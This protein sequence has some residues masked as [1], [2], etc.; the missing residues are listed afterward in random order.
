MTINMI[1]IAINII[2]EESAIEVHLILQPLK[3][4]RAT[5]SLRSISFQHQT[6]IW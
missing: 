1:E 2:G 4:H 6:R 5:E 3:V